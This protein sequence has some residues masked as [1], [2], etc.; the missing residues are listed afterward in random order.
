MYDQYI[1]VQLCP[2]LYEIKE[3]ESL[4]LFLSSIYMASLTVIFL[5]WVCC[6]KKIIL[7]AKYCGRRI[8]RYFT[9][10]PRPY[11]ELIEDRVEEESPSMDGVD[12]EEL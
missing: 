6:I 1:A 3:E 9:R 8:P 2:E 11:P 5:C 4:Y 7:G 12:V 10:T